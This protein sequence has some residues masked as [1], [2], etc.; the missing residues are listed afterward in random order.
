MRED[1]V[2][3]YLPASAKDTLVY[4]EWN[5]G[6]LFLEKGD[7][8][9]TP[10]TRSKAPVIRSKVGASGLNYTTKYNDANYAQEPRRGEK[11]GMRRKQE[12]IEGDGRM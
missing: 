12:E 2:Y 7:L 8:S 1:G 3:K 6:K 9:I 4:Q 11:V 5:D 10:K